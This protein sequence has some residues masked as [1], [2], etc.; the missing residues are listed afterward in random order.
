MAIDSTRPTYPWRFFRESMFLIISI[1]ALGLIIAIHEA[2]H[3]LAARLFKVG[4]IEY[5]IGMGPRIASRLWGNTRVSLRAMPFGGSCMMLGEEMDESH[6]EGNPRPGATNGTFENEPRKVFGDKILVDGRTYLREEQFVSK[7]AWQRFIIIAAGPVF[8]FILA[9]L[10]ALVITANYGYDRS[11][12]LKIEAGSPM[13]E[14]GIEEGDRITGLCMAGHTEP[15]GNPEHLGTE[16]DMDTNTVID[17]GISAETDMDTNTVISAEANGETSSETGMED[18][19]SPM[20]LLRHLFK[21]KKIETGRDIQLFMLEN[22]E[23]KDAGMAIGVRYLDASDGMKEKHAEVR[24]VYD[25]A[26][27]QNLLGFSYTTAFSEAGSVMEVIRYAF[28]DV[29]YCI[30]SAV[31]SVKLLIKGSVGRDDVMGPVRMVAVMDESMDEAADYGL[32]VAV[33]TLLNIMVLI[34]GSLGAT[35]LLPIPALDGGK[36]LFI[37]IEMITRH[38]VP[39]EIEGRIHFVGMMFLLLLMLMIL[40]NDVFMLMSGAP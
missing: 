5:S 32:T 25:E 23:A 37:I 27:G 19:P 21:Y 36:L 7:P 39:K 9:F 12:V 38:P 22:A 8:N 13:A 29:K 6:S 11:D 33:M 10:F 18:M 1:I 35:N 17:A 2:G 26:S 28:Y 20:D 16:T 30:K 24:A 14:A 4:V 40:F 3:F 31:L 34:S 15:L